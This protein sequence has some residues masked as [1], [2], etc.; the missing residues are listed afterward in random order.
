VKVHLMHQDPATAP[1]AQTPQ[2]QRN[3]TS[4]TASVQLPKH[5]HITPTVTQ[6]NFT[7]LS[8]T[9]AAA[10]PSFKYHS[11]NTTAPMQLHEHNLLSQ[12]EH[13]KFHFLLR[14]F[15]SLSLSIAETL[16]LIRATWSG[17]VH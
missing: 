8:A 3:N 4:T 6:S 9:A 5:H 1:I 10:A 2:H 14:S 17:I 15:A 13:S 11:I 12:L 7:R 16:P